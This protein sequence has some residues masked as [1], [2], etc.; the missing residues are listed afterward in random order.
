MTIDEALQ[1]EILL[2][3]QKDWLLDTSPVKVWEKSRRIGASYVEALTSVI[4]Y[5]SMRK[6]DGGMD[7]FYLSYDKEMTQ[8]FVYDCAFWARLHGKACSAMEETVIRDE[9]KDITVYKIR[10]DSG[11][12]IWGL[13]SE[14][15]VLRSKQ[16][17]IIIDEAAFVDDLSELM[18]AAMAMLMWGGS[19]SILSTHNGDDNPFNELVQK[20]KN[21]NLDYSLHRTTID[22]ALADGLYKRICDVR[23]KQWTK[24]AERQWLEK[25]IKDYGDG[26]D[27]EL[28][29]IPSRAGARYFPASLVQGATAADVPVFRWSMDDSFTFCD[30]IKR[31]AKCVEWFLKIKPVLAAS[32]NPVV[33]G[34]DFARSGDLT[35]L[36]FDEVLPQGRT[37]TLCVIELRNIPFDQQWQ[38]VF[39]CCSALNNFVGAAFDARG[40]GQMIAEKA[41]QEWRGIVNQVMATRAWYAENFPRLKNA[42]EEKTTDVPEDIFLKDDFKVIHVK[43]GVPLVDERSGDKKNRRHGDGCIAKTMAVF[44]AHEYDGKAYQPMTYE[45]VKIGNRYRIDGGDAWED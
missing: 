17:H 35:V 12:E 1:K 26:A 9:K 43:N 2:K 28:F 31:S 21:R 14:P 42:L 39:K 18:K 16:G 40:N 3:Y 34:E 20:I 24:D 13:P 22:D 4:L 7:C 6:A 27:E 30:A 25:L 11:F 38:M 36:W 10:F 44:A 5:A 37:H 33:L 45:S 32:K 15:R 41:A 23:K 8:Q 29:C 19:V